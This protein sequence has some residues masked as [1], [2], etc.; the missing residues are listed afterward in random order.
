MELRK[1]RMEEAAAVAALYEAGKL[2]L[3]NSGIPQWQDGYPNE[4]SAAADII[5]GCCYVLEE[6]DEL[7]GTA[8]I[9]FGAEPT[10]N[11]VYE[12]SWACTPE[13]YGFLHRVAVSPAFARRGLAGMFFTFAETCAREQNISVLRCDTHPDNLAMQRT[14]TNNGYQKR[15][16]IHLTNGDLRL[17][18]EKLL[19]AE[20]P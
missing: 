9:A 7:A 15:G 19:T 2:L 11:K 4:K 6:N 8:C 20:T 1:A 10:Y 14:L 13:C 12:G 18:Y 16:L 3:K 5:N 17:A